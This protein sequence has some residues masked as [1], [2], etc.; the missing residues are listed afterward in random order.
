MFSKV[1]AIRGRD[2]RRLSRGFSERRTLR[3]DPKEFSGQFQYAW[4][5]IEEREHALFMLSFVSLLP[6]RQ[7][8]RLMV[9]F[10]FAA[11]GQ[12]PGRYA[13]GL[14]HPEVWATSER[15]VTGV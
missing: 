2:T 8:P 14:R 11:R 5:L 12:V 4:A 13:G 10:S 7:S 1:Q 3:Q 9:S 15:G 6:R